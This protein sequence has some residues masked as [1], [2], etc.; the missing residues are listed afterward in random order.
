VDNV[1]GEFRETFHAYLFKVGLEEIVAAHENAKT[2]NFS[3]II[4]LLSF[5]NLFQT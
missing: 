5:F 4:I 1:V 2:H 3:S